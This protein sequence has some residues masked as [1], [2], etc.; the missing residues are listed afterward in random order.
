M[1]A[2]MIALMVARFAHNAH[3]VRLHQLKNQ[4]KNHINQHCCNVTQSV[5]GR[6]NFPIPEKS[7]Y[8]A[9]TFSLSRF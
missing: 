1:I 5:F 3:F 9:D 4:F 6:H 2:L 7:I 8:L